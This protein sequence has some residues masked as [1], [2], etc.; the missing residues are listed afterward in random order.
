MTGQYYSHFVETKKIS[1]F[2]GK[3]TTAVPL[4]GVVFVKISN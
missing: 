1:N 2:V 3:F 4:H